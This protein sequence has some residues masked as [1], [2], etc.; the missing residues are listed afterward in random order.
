MLQLCLIQFQQAPEH[1]TFTLVLPQWTQ[2]DWWE[3]VDRYFQVTRTIATSTPAYTRLRITPQ[4]D[5]LDKAQIDNGRVILGCQKWPLVILHLSRSTRIKIDDM[6]LAHVRFGH[7]GARTLQNIWK[8]GLATG[9]KD[10]RH[11]CSDLLCHICNKV[12]A[13]RPAFRNLTDKERTPLASPLHRLHI[14]IHGP[15]ST[16][17]VNGFRYVLGVICAGSG[18][19]W[20]RMLKLK[21]DASAMLKHILA[22]I[23]VDP[24]LSMNFLSARTI[25]TSDNA[26]EFATDLFNETL[27][28]YSVKHD[29][30]SPYNHIENL[31]IERLW[32]TLADMAR[33]FLTMSAIPLKFWPAAWRHAAHVYVLLP[34]PH[35]DHSD[36]ILSPFERL[37]GQA[38]SL[39]HLRV[40]GCDGYA[41][42]EPGAREGGKLEAVR[43]RHG[44]YVGHN[45]DNTRTIILLDLNTE[46]AFTSGMVKCTEDLDKLGRVISNP[47]IAIASFDFVDMDSNRTTR[48][49]PFSASRKDFKSVTSVL[50]H[51]AYFDPDDKETY[52]LVEL[53]TGK[54]TFW[55]YLLNF[56]YYDKPPERAR[57]MFDSHLRHRYNTST[58]RSNSFYPI[59]STIHTVV[60]TVTFTGIIISTDYHSARK[61]GVI[62]WSSDSG[63][64]DLSV[65]HQ[66]LRAA[67]IVEFSNETIYRVGPLVAASEYQEPT[68]VQAAT[69]MPDA[70]EW[71][72]AIASEINNMFHVKKC[73]QKVETDS[74][75]H[76]AVVLKMK[77]VLASYTVFVRV[78]TLSPASYRI[79][80]FL[81][82]AARLCAAGQTCTDH[83]ALIPR[84]RFHAPMGRMSA[85]YKKS[86]FCSQ[87][88]YHKIFQN[89]EV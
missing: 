38:P 39:A 5:N 77:M 88:H 21:S 78:T 8:S 79:E 4:D 2:T 30:T 48:P 29:F 47:Q 25:L 54:T 85:A 23:N 64:T 37:T 44:R 18:Y 86:V 9:L 67:D 82:A 22:E 46:T 41:Y 58:G 3:L 87:S 55:T 34:R 7:A 36:S 70:A 27:A 49:T 14:D 16:V 24:L 10:V 71:L 51:T 75:P 56:L 6:L 63:D 60:D 74:I 12:K 33:T 42:L 35:R 20:I 53:S 40:F 1:T 73:L 81:Y 52:G 32:R 17:S 43:A 80:T 59:F 83:S 68:S 61:Y 69:R 13:T 65:T 62:Y 57:T 72:V 76:D 45:N 19:C 11:A 84:A 31:F 26:K 28:Q 89:G 15:L 66:D 50:N